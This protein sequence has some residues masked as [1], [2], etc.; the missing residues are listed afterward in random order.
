MRIGIQGKPSAEVAQHTGQRFYIHAAG[1]GHGSESM[2]QI[3]EA[4]MLLNAGLC[5]QLPV[6]SGHCIRTPVAAGAGRREQEGIVRVLSMLL[7]QHIHR[8]LGQRHP[9]HGVLRFQLCY[10][11]LPVDVGD[12]LAHREDAVFHVQVA[13]KDLLYMVLPC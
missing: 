10:H 5:Q 13:P 3:M 6:D 2:A 11:Q 7:H 12:L 4:H 1:E 9:A 8:L